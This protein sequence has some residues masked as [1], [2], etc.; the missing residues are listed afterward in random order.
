MLKSIYDHKM[1]LKGMIDA[2]SELLQKLRDGQA[3]E[4]KLRVQVRK[5]VQQV[6]NA[7]ANKITE[8]DDETFLEPEPDFHCQGPSA[9]A[10]GRE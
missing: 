10:T 8:F 9:W 2:H 1:E 3:L 4:M 7:E 6:I 5:L